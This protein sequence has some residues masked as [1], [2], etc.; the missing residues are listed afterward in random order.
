MAITKD[1]VFQAANDL[2]AN[3]QNPTLAAVRKALGS[4]SYS[5]ISEFMTE[6]RES[7][8]ALPESIQEPTPPAIL[9]KTTE[10][11]ANIWSTAMI[12]SNTRLATERETMCI[13]ENQLR[14]QLKDAIA[15]ADELTAEID[16]LQTQITAMK[17]AEATAHAQLA[18]A[19]ERAVIAEARTD[20]LRRELDYAHSQLLNAITPG[21]AMK[22]TTPRPK[23]TPK[24]PNDAATSQL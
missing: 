4:G 24:K 12:I 23:K 18:A 2:N 3:G 20:E 19:N 14:N 13:A 22:P 1:Q 15:T 7:Q 21:Q 11:A 9:E 6:W 16:Q 5:T 17:T 8:N 10:L